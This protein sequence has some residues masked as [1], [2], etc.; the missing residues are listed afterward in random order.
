MLRVLLVVAT[1]SLAVALPMEDGPANE[2]SEGGVMSLIQESGLATL[3]KGGDGP[4]TFQGTL[5]HVVN[6]FCTEYTKQVG[7]GPTY[8]SELVLLQHKWIQADATGEKEPFTKYLGALAGHYCPDHKATETSRC[9]VLQLLGKAV[10]AT[11]KWNAEKKGY[12]QMTIDVASHFCKKLGKEE[13][14]CPLLKALSKH[15]FTAVNTGDGVKYTKYVQDLEDHYCKG[16][17]RHSPDQ[18]CSI[19][20]LM[21]T[22]IPSLE[23]QLQPANPSRHHM[24]AGTNGNV[25]AVDDEIMATTFSV[26]AGNVHEGLATP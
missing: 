7:E 6:R 4:F 12:Y 18:R 24:P 5:Q 15:F 17:V 13:L 3:A 26:H 14:F 16:A 22:S 23:L 21:H 25:P 20:P 10:P 1:L 9:L 11:L 19:L 2:L 8:C